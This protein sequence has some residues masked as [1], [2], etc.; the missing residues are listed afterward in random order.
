MSNVV[1]NLMTILINYLFQISTKSDVWSLGCIFYL[2]V[3][4]RTPFSNI[5]NFYAKYSAITSTETKINY[6]PI[7]M[8]YPPML[9]EVS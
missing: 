2:C 4:R 8:Y 1:C 5:K 9:L 7:P 3:Y 6:P